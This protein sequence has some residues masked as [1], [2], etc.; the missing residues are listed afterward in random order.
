MGR[1][2]QVES[3]ATGGEGLGVRV[4]GAP[5]TM[6]ESHHPSW[7]GVIVFVF[8]REEILAAHLQQTELKAAPG[9]PN[10]Q[11]QPGVIPALWPDPLGSVEKRMRP[12]M[13]LS[14]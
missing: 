2:P 6:G 4:G 3:L 14:R 13:G 9:S 7:E 5:S 1:D 10:N 11:T 8:P 12:L